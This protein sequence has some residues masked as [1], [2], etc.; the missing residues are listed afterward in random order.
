MR[1]FYGLLTAILLLFIALVPAGQ[2]NPAKNILVEME[3]VGKGKVTIE[4]YSKE[5][6]KTV[7]HFLKLCKSKFYDGILVHRVVPD[8]VVQAGDPLT[9]KNG[10]NDP[11]IGSHGSGP[12]GKSMD[13]PFE[14]NDKTHETGTIAMALTQPRSATGDSQWFINLVPNHRLDGD[15]CVFGKVSKGMDIV[16]KI[17]KGDKIVAIKKID[18]K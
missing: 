18:A 2:A 4:L 13:I 8:F 16:Q 6:P 7:D 17:Q 14:T 15:Y 11:T 3:I 1:R 12:N 10:V 5:A 9:K